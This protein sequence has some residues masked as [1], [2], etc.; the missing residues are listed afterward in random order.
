M[1]KYEKYEEMLYVRPTGGGLVLH[2]AM[3]GG[4]FLDLVKALEGTQKIR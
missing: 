1:K 3:L 4:R 2:P